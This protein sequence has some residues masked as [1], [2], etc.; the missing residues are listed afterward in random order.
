[1]NVHYK[2]I[3]TAAYPEMALAIREIATELQFDV[4]IV[5][6]ILEEASQEVEKLVAKGGYEVII[7]RAGT[8]AVIQKNVNLPIVH[9]DSGHFDLL[10]SFIEARKMGEKIGFI[11]YP[12]EGFLF[13]FEK[14]NELIDFEVTLY[15]YYSYEELVKQVKQAKKDGIDVIVGGGVRT[16]NLATNYG[17]KS[18]LVLPNRRSIKRS[19][20]LANQVA[21][22]RMLIK[23]KVKQL[24]AV[25]DTSGE[26][27]LFI[28]MQHVIE[29]CNPI[30]Q[31]LFQIR[32]RDI[33]GKHV[34]EIPSLELKKIIRKSLKYAEETNFT[35]GNI[36]ISYSPVVVEENRI[37]SFINCREVSSIQKLE[38]KIRRD[39]YSKGLVSKYS[40]E[41]IIHAEP[42]MTEVIEL[43]KAYAKT[44]STVLI[45]GES[46]TG[47]E[48]FAQSIHNGSM[49]SKGPFVAVNCAALPENLLESELFG[50]AD[51]AFTGALKGGRQGV[52]ELAHEGTIFLD[53][54]G[55][56][57]LHIQTRLLR[58]LQ[59]KEVMRLGAEQ[60]IPINIRV[61]AATNHRLWK[62]VEEEKFRLDLY[63]RL[64]ILHMEVPPLRERI[65]DIPL[66]VN[67][68]LR[69]MNA[70][71]TFEEMPQSIQQFLKNYS[72]PGN[73]RQ[74]ENI[75]E[76]Y[77]LYAQNVG[78]DKL[79]QLL[80]NDLKRE[81]SDS[82]QY[83]TK[84]TLLVEKGTLEDINRQVILKML[85][86][87]DDNKTVVAD[88]L[89]ISRTTLWKKLSEC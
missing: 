38:Y 62:L 2:M 42:K 4:T 72:W 39:L 29:A 76:R 58:V 83:A 23:E 9:S 73:V 89:G 74:L 85:K 32:E 43:A 70:D 37:G 86:E 78:F 54:I 6:G 79:E 28:N 46:G 1:M 16:A 60:V 45:I 26:G 63:F 3:M 68:F 53:E 82:T 34:D 35:Q 22:D 36:N 69:Q 31:K 5:E 17:I 49:R 66:I 14:I 55:E 56:I 61:I 75:V 88:L 71:S 80:I 13:D 18:M 8:A 50:Y 57:P 87:H 33:L 47:K 19:L 65:L 11:T 20:I 25:I 15:R 10:L 44:E 59:Q 21:K 51:G 24:N 48:L 27:I 40:F 30:A 81:M 77:L 67:S 41:D 64:S 7:S 52:F 84:E 12:E